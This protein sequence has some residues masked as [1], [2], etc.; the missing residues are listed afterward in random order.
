MAKKITYKYDAFIS[1]RHSEIDKFIAENLHKRLEAYVPPRNLDAALVTGERRIKRVF[2]DEEELP[3]ATNLEDPIIAALTNTD[4]LI[5][6]CTPRLNQSEWCKKEIATFIE[7][8][9]RERVLLALCEGE[10]DMSFPEL[11]RYKEERIDNYNGTFT[12]RRIPLEPLAAD[13]R[14]ET[15]KEIL[16]KMDVEI[17]RLLSRMYNVNFDDLRRRH[18]EREVRRN[19]IVASAV[20]GFSL[21][22]GVVGLGTAA[23][24]SNQN[25]LIGE[26][27]AKLSEQQIQLVKNQSVSY[28]ELAAF[29]AD[30]DPKEALRM[31]YE[32]STESDGITMEY[33]SQ[34][35]RLMTRLL[36]LYDSGNMFKL[37][38]VFKNDSATCAVYKSSN[39]TYF[40]TV[41]I[42]GTCYIY[43]AS[44]CSLV[45]IIQNVA[46]DG[47]AG[48]YEDKY[49]VYGSKSESSYSSSFE[50]VTVYNLENGQMNTV[51]ASG[52][53]LKTIDGQ[54]LFCIY[55]SDSITFYDINTLEVKY[56]Y[57]FNDYASDINW[58][59]LYTTDEFFAFTDGELFRSTDENGNSVEDAHT[60]SCENT[61]YVVGITS[62]ELLYSTRVDNFKI[63]DITTIDDVSIITMVNNGFNATGNV[64]IALK[65]G[66][67]PEVTPEITPEITPET[68]PEVTTDSEEGETITTEEGEEPITEES[69]TEDIGEDLSFAAAPTTPSYSWG[70]LW[71]VIDDGAS[72]E[73]VMTNETI[74]PGSIYYIMKNVVKARD[75]QTGEATLNA[76]CDTN[77]KHL[78]I[79]DNKLTAFL[80]DGTCQIIITNYAIDAYTV[81][82]FSSDIE[83]KDVIV[84]N[85]NIYVIPRSGSL[86]Y[87]YSLTSSPNLETL[88][89]VPEDITFFAMGTSYTAY[90]VN[91]FEAECDKYGLDTS[92]VYN[93]CYSLDEKLAIANMYDGTVQLLDVKKSKVICSIKNETG[94]YFTSVAEN[95]DYYF[96]GSHSVSS[97]MINKETLE[98]VA[99]IDGLAGVDDKN[100]YISDTYYSPSYPNDATF[101]YIPI[102]DADTV[103]KLAEEALADDD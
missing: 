98:V 12:T 16:K 34:A 92:S 41:S 11:M 93:I 67:L 22:T 79:G 2:R 89:A 17:F 102:Y 45:K 10:P 4:W 20:T 7:M 26:Q 103:L 47:A 33:T 83:T 78:R 25:V 54:N 73:T 29:Q 18:H 9:G 96:V 48:F 82:W 100:I 72:V 40:A 14:G 13:F 27:N 85:G 91:D 36:H 94:F 28:A 15:K 99:D 74:A 87:D 76:I 19:L 62:G 69:T 70:E 55:D 51:A 57:N 68:T 38:S 32:A 71:R 37:T 101:G 3:L 56:K 39:S 1:Y 42:N 5:V 53:R 81:S 59:S 6:I 58:T 24:I 65:E 46:D 86:I 80:E 8:H 35:Q 90:Y 95:S 75:V 31:A 63:K 88:D 21:I 49:F 30:T 97:C 84:S 61:L 77:I 43:N 50:E 23:Y 60:L 44:T 66:I 64:I 52:Y